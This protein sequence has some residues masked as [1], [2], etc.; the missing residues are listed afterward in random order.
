MA[1]SYQRT[2][3]VIPT[4]NRAELAC[5]AITSVLTQ[6]GADTVSILVSDNSTDETESTRLQQFCAAQNDARLQY[7]R[8]PEPLPM[9]KHWEWAMEQTLQ[10]AATSH[11][12]YLTDRMIFKQGELCELLKAAA[13]Y[14]TKIISYGNDGIYDLEEPIRL[15]QV[16]WTGNLYE[17]PSSEFLRLTSQMVIHH[18]LPRLLNCL[19]P[20]PVLEA[21]KSRYGNICTA[22]APDFCFAY[23]SLEREDSILFFDRTTL[24]HY[25]LDRSNGMSQGRGVTNK[26]H[27][28]FLANLESR[29]LNY[30]APVPEFRTVANAI[31]HEYAIVQQ[32]SGSPKFPEL[33]RANYFNSISSEIQGIA[34]PALQQEMRE[35]LA[36]QDR[37]TMQ[38]NRFAKL[39]KLFSLP[40]LRIKFWWILTGAR[41]QPLWKKLQ[42]RYGTEPPG[43]RD[44]L[45][46]FGTVKEAL[47]Y[48]STHPRRR[49][50]GASYLETLVK[51]KKLPLPK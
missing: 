29:Q 22:I 36:R 26:D 23:R 12:L 46:E 48:S 25:A 19:V 42:N 11:V 4:R 41:F 27:A 37:G 9:G 18:G 2:C 28:D 51:Y 35:L 30:A 31:I 15:V 49:N 16:S 40:R 3:I 10:D 13:K 45:T 47:E 7:V 44:F 32:E 6:T 21:V 1:F 24:V 38:S 14:P 34:N 17:V 50:P 8:P 43:V 20:R 39:A 5:N 33:N